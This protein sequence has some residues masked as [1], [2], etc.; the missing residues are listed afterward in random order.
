ML[1]PPAPPSPPPPALGAVFSPPSAACGDVCGALFPHKKKVALPECFI[2]VTGVEST[3]GNFHMWNGGEVFLDAFQFGP[4]YSNGSYTIKVQKTINKGSRFVLKH[5]LISHRGVRE[6]V[7]AW[8]AFRSSSFTIN[9]YACVCVC[10]CLCC[11]VCCTVFCLVL[12]C[13]V[14]CGV[15]VCVVLCCFVTCNDSDGRD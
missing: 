4:R 3:V 10:L 5:R 2:G 11:A 13:A 14:L 15:C 8:C 1:P 9:S 6:M 7:A 12:S